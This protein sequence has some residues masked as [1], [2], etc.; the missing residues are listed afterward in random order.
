MDGPPRTYESVIVHPLVLLSVTDH[1]NRVAKDTKNRVVGVLLGES[2][3]GRLEI[4][5]CFAVPFDED[6]HD[7]KIF[8]LDHGYLESMF[9]MHKK[10]SAKERI[11]GFYSTGPKIRPADIEIDRLFRSKYAA[12]PVFVIV[13]VRPGQSGLPTQ[14]YE[15]VQID[16]AHAS[17]A[18][19]NGEP[20][21][22]FVHL[23]SQVG[24]TEAE[25]VGVEHLLRDVN[26]PT[27]GS[28]AGQVG[29]VHEGLRGL[30]DSLRVLSAYLN[31]VAE[32]RMPAN[33]EII[34][35][36]QTV[37]NRLPDTSVKEMSDA[38]AEGLNDQTLS[39]FIGTLTRSVLSLHDLL[40]N[41]TQY[42][43]VEE[44]ESKVEDKAASAGKEKEKKEEA[45]K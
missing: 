41:R 18:I 39:V 44:E 2:Y 28:L 45:K 36:A 31:A 38:I 1:Y 19:A 17:S 24:A 7:P 37:L 8:F 13:D 5:N 9:Y 6:A 40:N 26:D 27:V 30:T 10:V 43:K 29:Q 20:D 12:H 25:E 23:A 4:T 21:R 16:G 22:E 42:R 35:N 11:V 32:G 3:K 15:S 34:A 14:A 33:P